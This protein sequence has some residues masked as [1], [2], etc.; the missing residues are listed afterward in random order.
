[1]DHE[2][3]QSRTRALTSL[4][5][6]LN[7]GGGDGQAFARLVDAVYDDLR[8]IANRRMGQRFDGRPLAALTLQPTAIAGDAIM[9]LRRQRAAWQNSDHFFAIATRLIERLIRDYRKRRGAAKRGA[10]ARHVALDERVARSV[11]T[12]TPSGPVEPGGASGIDSFSPILRALERLHDEY[13]RK[14]EVV[15]LHV[16]CGH[17]LSKIALMLELSPAQIQRDWSFAQSWLKREAAGAGG[18]S[19]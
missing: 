12:P 17:P 18:H 4:L 16:I 1:M 3:G 19:T 9:E 15:T 8:R 14:A 11:A 7:G 13:P 5:D 6:Q 2:S 10:G